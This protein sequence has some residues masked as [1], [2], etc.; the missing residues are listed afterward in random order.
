MTKQFF[1]R[2]GII[3]VLMLSGLSINLDA[4]TPADSQNTVS[5]P[6]S[7]FT[8]PIKNSTMKIVRAIDGATERYYVPPRYLNQPGGL[9]KRAAAT[10]VV[11]YTGF[12]AEA[13]T[14]FQYA[15]DIWESLLT[16]PV[17]IRVD[18]NWTPLGPG[19]LGS[20]GASAY[21][22]D[23]ITIYPVALAEKMDGK[24]LNGSN[25]DIEANF[26]SSFSSWYLGTDGIVDSSHWD[27]VSVVLH[28]L[29]HGLGY[30]GS[31][32]YNSGTGRW[33][34]GTGMPVIFDR[35]LYNGSGQSLINTG[36]FP[37]PSGA[38]GSQLVSQN[39]YFN[40]PGSGSIKLYAPSTWSSGS[41][42]YHTDHVTNPTNLMNYA[43][44]NGVAIHDPGSIIM[45]QMSDI[46]WGDYTP[47]AETYSI[48][49]SISGASSVTV[50]LSGDANQT[51][52][53]NFSGNYSFSGL[54]EGSYT[55]TPSKTGYGFSPT[56]RTYSPLNTDLSS[57]NF[58]ATSVTYTISG[59]ISGATEVSVQL[60]GT[61]SRSTITDAMGEYSFEDLPGGGTYTITPS[62]SGYVFTP[63]SRNY[64]PLN[65]DQ[66]SQDF[67]AVSTLYGISGRI[68]GA[69]QVVIF[70]TGAVIAST[71]TDIDGDYSFTGLAGGVNYTVIP[72]K[73][74][75]AFTPSSRSY[76]PLGGN[77]TTQ[78]FTGIQQTFT[79]GGQVNDVFLSAYKG[80]LGTLP[81][82]PHP[83]QLPVKEVIIQ[84]TGGVNRLDTTDI[85]GSYLFTGLLATN[86]YRI[87]PLKPYYTFTPESLVIQHLIMDSLHN[88]F[89]AVQQKNHIIGVVRNSV[90]QGIP[91]A[92]I[93]L[94]GDAAIWDTTD[95]A[96]LFDF[97]GLPA[98]Q[99][100]TITPSKSLYSFSPVSQTITRLIRDT[101]LVFTG[102]LNPF[103]LTGVIRTSTGSAI[104]NAIVHLTG[105]INRLDTTDQNGAY[106]FT[107]LSAYSHLIVRPIKNFHTFLPDSQIIS[108][109]ESDTVQNFT[110]M[111]QLFTITGQ[112]LDQNSQ[113]LTNVQIQL[114]GGISAITISGPT[115]LY[116]FSGLTGGSVFT[117]KA[118]K[119]YYR[120]N[121]DSTTITS[122]VSDTVIPL[123]AVLRRYT[124]SGQVRLITGQVMPGVALSLH[125]DTTD[126]AI[127]DQNGNFSFFNLKAGRAYRLK[128]IKEFY[129]FIP[130]STIIL[131]L[132]ND[133]MV[134]FIAQKQNF[135]V[136]GQ[137]INEL[138]QAISQ[139]IIT[140]SG[141]DDRKD[142]SDTQGLFAFPGL[143]AGSAYMIAATK[144]HYSITPPH[145]QIGNLK[146]DTFLVFSAVQNHYA[147]S[148]RVTTPGGNPLPDVIISLNDNPSDLDTTDYNGDYRFQALAAGKVYLIK[149]FLPFYSFQP[150]SLT[151]LELSHDTTANFTGTHKNYS[152]SG[153]VYRTTTPP[154]EALPLREVMI[155]LSGNDQDSVMTDS[156]GHYIFFVNAGYSYSVT[157]IK[158]YY[159]F[160]PAQRFYPL[161]V[162]N[163]I[164]DFI[165]KP[166]FNVAKLKF[167]VYP[168]SISKKNVVWLKWNTNQLSQAEIRYG[169]T[170]QNLQTILPITNERMEHIY[171]LY[172]LVPERTYYYSI[173][174]L[175]GQDSLQSPLDSFYI[176]SEI[177]DTLKPYSISQSI[178]TYQTQAFIQLELNEPCL[179]NIVYGQSST[180]L[181]QV[182]SSSEF[183]RHYM[184]PLTNLSPGMTYYYRLILI[185]L[186]GNTT[187][188]N[189]VQQKSG[190]ETSSS[191]TFTTLS[192]ADQQAPELTDIEILYYDHGE[193]A[194]RWQSSEPARYWLDIYQGVDSIGSLDHTTGYYLNRHTTLGDLPIL[195]DYSLQLTLTDPENNR[196][197]F[198]INLPPEEKT[199]D[200]PQITQ[201]EYSPSDRT[202]YWI[203]DTYST[204]RVRWLAQGTLTY[205]LA[206]NELTKI[207]RMWAE[208]IFPEHSFCYQIISCFPGIDVCSAVYE[209][210]YQI[211][212]VADDNPLDTRQALGQYF[213]YPNPFNSQITIAFEMIRSEHVII[214]IYNHLGEKV[215]ALIDQILPAG[216]HQVD[217][218]GHTHLNQPVSSG[219]Y[220]Y[221]I[222]IA[223]ETYTGK[224]V[225][226]K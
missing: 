17:T 4:Q 80:G 40:G 94:S 112:T 171:T 97:A 6:S 106:G 221:R 26:N 121:P 176:H 63:E 85:G 170:P 82:D 58:S 109:L 195:G 189:P 31:M 57:Q 115:G 172:S 117:I 148:G 116:S 33:G 51:T 53:T 169:E 119:Q 185:D 160:E 90:G 166:N 127:T 179:I 77:Q 52:T 18:A 43:L 215:Q 209:D 79:I 197:V 208:T 36:L 45:N 147:L 156:A 61:V 192:E 142:T 178:T 30:I 42:I 184:I 138:G 153:T 223:Q 91:A 16:T 69:T 38:L 68:S 202:F 20:C 29:C 168:Y 211:N 75:Y 81:G 130:D 218:D 140:L 59:S 129:Q 66:S 193:A 125:G 5:Q 100:Y 137:V 64:N 41:S 128:P 220:F 74:G 15:V 217:W 144:N 183:C 27:F 123:H 22:D 25:S 34:W 88:H 124:L 201:V 47:P 163:E 83:P 205:M 154:L 71:N 46:G 107:N 149:P 177:Q 65:T 50:T 204:S 216:A 2:F 9:Q 131:S 158:N 62:R 102:Q 86:E 145:Y 56:E 207:H 173:L 157:P 196:S 120:F 3:G 44:Y 21:Y 67:A 175:A 212:P 118:Q 146:S 188:Q 174:A 187:I 164:Q 203:S 136:S 182:Y 99:N 14:A 108:S 13:Q 180:L 114:S 226:L 78:D 225:L 213:S 92:L 37:N 12:S 28:E 101:S 190:N 103:I 214:T 89:T 110:G 191:T 210:C 84:L 113:P 60:S 199:P 96:G 8:G 87:K 73:P 135:T 159:Y 133:S 7:R 134:V 10:V 35:Y 104:P 23:G 143:M 93:Q 24:E 111:A 39:V 167:D 105:D 206:D 72:S 141:G 19:I 152:I 224:M 198:N 194:L 70:L 181:N 219:I 139:T 162:Q 161:L 95:A 48:S 150:D 54:A 76:T 55:I 200:P 122:L 151:I 126:Q 49:G 1:L 132:E 98:G 222:E 32:S 165:I 186:T 11:T 155:Y